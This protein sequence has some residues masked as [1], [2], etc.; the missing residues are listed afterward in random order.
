VAEALIGQEMLLSLAK[1]RTSPKGRRPTWWRLPYQLLSLL[2]KMADSRLSLQ[3][4]L[5][6][7]V[8]LFGSSPGSQ[9]DGSS[10]QM[11]SK[12]GY[13][14]GEID[15]LDRQWTTAEKPLRT[16]TPAAYIK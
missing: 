7:L 1:S 4:V 14:R 3:A 8:S 15:Q 9:S 6:V 16:G 10:T 2:E 11:L 5:S 13:H 12:Q